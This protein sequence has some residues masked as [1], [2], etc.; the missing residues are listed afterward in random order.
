M[1]V[2]HTAEFD[3]P[4]GA[5]AC[6]STSHGLCFIELP[7]ASGGFAGGPAPKR[8]LLALERRKHPQQGEL[9]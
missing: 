8:H 2:V 3:S 7:R 5:M 1:E 4:F 6:V 9:L